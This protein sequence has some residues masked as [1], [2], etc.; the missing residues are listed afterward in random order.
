MLL[1]LKE[2]RARSEIDAA[3]RADLKE[4]MVRIFGLSGEDSVSVN[5]IACA[6]PGCPDIETVIL[7]MRAGE[8]TIALKVPTLMADISDIEIECIAA[9]H[10]PRKKF[11]D[12]PALSTGP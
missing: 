4:R 8:P 6:D 11:E 10:P 3:T 12:R 5:Q 2:W 1:S 9:L 7:L